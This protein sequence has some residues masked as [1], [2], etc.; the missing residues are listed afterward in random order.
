MLLPPHHPQ[1]ETHT[2]PQS[3]PQKRPGLLRHRRHH[4]GPARPRRHT[5]Y[6]SPPRVL[7]PR[8]SNNTLG[9]SSLNS[10]NRESNGSTQD[11]YR[12]TLAA[13]WQLQAGELQADE[14]IED[15]FSGGDGWTLAA[16]RSR[17]PK[18]VRLFDPRKDSDSDS[19]STNTI[20][21]TPTTVTGLKKP[22]DTLSVFTTMTATSKRKVALVGGEKKEVDELEVREDFVSWRM[23]GR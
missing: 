8:H 19:T 2:S 17:G 10:K 21:T 3:L 20:P 15:I 22:S 18:S 14:C 7:A 1:M 5:K 23:P 6:L 11:V 4:R 9:I 16:S 13:S 12:R